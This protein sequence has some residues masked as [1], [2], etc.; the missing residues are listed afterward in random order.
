MLTI[1]SGDSR[2]HGKPSKH[3]MSTPTGTQWNC[4]CV[5]SLV[6]KLVVGFTS[7]LGLG[8]LVNMFDRA[9]ARRV[10]RSAGGN[11]A[12]IHLRANRTF[13]MACFQVW[14]E[15]F[16]PCLKLL[17][18]FAAL[19]ASLTFE[20]SR[21]DAQTLRWTVKDPCMLSEAHAVTKEII[22]EGTNRPLLPLTQEHCL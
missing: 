4:F 13:S 14:K 19:G 12:F 2:H 7:P 15:N 21:A 10:D 6:R 16:R 11:T 3:L 5:D 20:R 8:C 9:R 18:V 22:S 17:C 1:E